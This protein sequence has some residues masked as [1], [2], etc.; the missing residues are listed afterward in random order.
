MISE[1]RCPRDRIRLHARAKHFLHFAEI[2]KFSVDIVTRK[3]DQ[4]GIRRFD[5]LLN[6][7]ET[8]HI[9]I[10][11]TFLEVRAL[12]LSV[13]RRVARAVQ[14][15]DLHIGELQNAK[16]RIGIKDGF[17]CVAVDFGNHNGFI[18]HI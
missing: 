10:G 5:Q 9:H 3:N 2:V 15:D 11:H 6:I 8:T 4:I 18:L 12:D 14:T 13:T 1:Y 16:R 17:R 7:R